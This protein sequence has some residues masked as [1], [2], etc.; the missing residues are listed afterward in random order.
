MLQDVMLH[1]GVV[2]MGVNANVGL[3]GKNKVHY[4]LEDTVRIG[5]AGDPMDDMIGAIIV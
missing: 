2:F 4:A 3:V 1:D 5:N